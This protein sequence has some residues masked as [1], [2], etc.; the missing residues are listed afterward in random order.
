MYCRHYMCVREKEN[1]KNKGIT[2]KMYISIGKQK[3]G[4][5]K[6]M[7]MIHKASM[8]LKEKMETIGA[9]AIF[10]R[11]IDLFFFWFKFYSQ[12]FFFQIH[13]NLTC[14]ESFY[15]SCSYFIYA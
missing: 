9:I 13:S 12:I 15:R 8:I 4:R 11:K 1:Y 3:S 14:I 5:E 10:D 6:K 7:M 2:K